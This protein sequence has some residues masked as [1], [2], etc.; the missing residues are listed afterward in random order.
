MGLP[1]EVP[2]GEYV[3]MT[4]QDNGT[5]IDEEVIANIFEPFFT[6]K[7]DGSGLGLSTVYGIERQSGG[8]VHVENRPQG[9][10][11]LGCIFRELM[12]PARRRPNKLSSF[13]RAPNRFFESAKQSIDLVLSNIDL[14]FL[15]KPFSFAELTTKISELLD[16]SITD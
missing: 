11:S 7:D 2:R 16:S 15:S 8:H 6:T 4:V 3:V 10:R 5:G 9:A 14:A 13:S 12:K 1:S